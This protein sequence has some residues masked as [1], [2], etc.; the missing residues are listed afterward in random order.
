MIITL[1][2]CLVAECRTRGATEHKWEFERPTAREIQRMQKIAG[3][4]LDKWGLA[5]QADGMGSEKIDA[6]LVLVDILHRRDGIIVPFE[7]IDLDLFDLDFAVDPDPDEAAEDE[8]GKDPAPTP[9]SPR[10][11]APSRTGS[12]SGRAPKG[13][14][15]RRS[16]T[17]PTA[18]GAGTA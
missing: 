5:L 11:K 15:R 13:E 4:E 14:S 17:T 1:K 10:R 12:T 2:N 16:T 7:D 6:A 9:A 3:M 8:T 18:S